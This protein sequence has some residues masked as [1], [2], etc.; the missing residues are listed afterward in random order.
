MTRRRRRSNSFGTACPVHFATDLVCGQ[1]SDYASDDST[2]HG[3][4]HASSWS[5]N[6]ADS[7]A[8]AGTPSGS[9]R[10]SSN[11]CTHLPFTIFEKSFH[12]AFVYPM[13]C[14]LPITTSVSFSN[15]LE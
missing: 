2:W 12:A 11:H 13:P 6:K 3:P 15:G 14:R 5:G 4:R 7:T 10:K 1:G 8:D 9:T